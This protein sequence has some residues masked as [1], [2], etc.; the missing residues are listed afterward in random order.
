VV[1]ICWAEKLKLHLIALAVESTESKQSGEYH[2]KM[3]IIAVCIT[4]FS[5]QEMTFT[6]KVGHS[7]QMSLLKI[8]N[9]VA[10]QFTANA[11]ALWWS[12][13]NYAIMY[14]L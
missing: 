13:C 11:S 5:Y 6:T 9:I 2:Y 4:T 8:I 10:E 12:I 3:Q 14:V 7:L 1:G